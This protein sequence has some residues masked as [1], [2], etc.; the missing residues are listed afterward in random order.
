[1]STLTKSKSTE[2]DTVETAE[3]FAAL[4]TSG[5]VGDVR[6]L[7]KQLKADSDGTEAGI[8][9]GIDALTAHK[10]V[11]DKRH[12]VG[13]SVA[14]YLLR[15]SESCTFAELAQ[16]A[17][18]V[19]EDGTPRL[20]I[21]KQHALRGEVI[22]KVGLPGITYNQLAAATGKAMKDLREAVRE[23]GKAAERQKKIT[24]VVLG[25]VEAKSQ[26]ARGE[27]TAPA[28]SAQVGPTDE[29]VTSGMV[30]SGTPTDVT[31]STAELIR[32]LRDVCE[33]LDADRVNGASINQRRSIRSAIAALDARVEAA[34]EAAKA[35]SK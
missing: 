23:P 33:E 29:T 8:L 27:R 13:V 11:A 16:H 6:T 4:L 10:N 3:A 28:P 21:V 31:V 24:A 2:I 25:A 35:A 26:A 19:A 30:S 34:Q 32:R 5:K 20:A 7:E 17:G 12:A 22:A 15:E 1:M 14:A 9:S 18:L